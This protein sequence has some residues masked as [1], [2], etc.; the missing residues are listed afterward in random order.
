MYG[1]LAGPAEALFKGAA[2][3]IAVLV[4]SFMICW[5]TT[6]GR[7][8]KAD[9]ERQVEAIV[10]RDATL[11]LMSFSFIIVFRE[12]FETVLFLTSFLL[13]GVSH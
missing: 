2:A 13:N 11:G 8:F 3:L 4:L 5:M 6:K 7:E 1:S 12:G 9:V 10:A